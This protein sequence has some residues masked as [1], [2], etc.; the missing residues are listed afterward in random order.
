MRS[1]FN[2]N[3]PAGF[4]Q[5]FRVHRRDH[6]VRHLIAYAESLRIMTYWLTGVF[7]RAFLTAA[8]SARWFVCLPGPNGS[9]VFLPVC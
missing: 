6:S 7:S 9:P 3:M 4:F 1:M 5:L 8:S 2:L